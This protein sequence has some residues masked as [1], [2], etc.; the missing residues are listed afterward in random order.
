MTSFHYNY[1]NALR[2]A[3]VF[4]IFSFVKNRSC[5]TKICITK[6]VVSKIHEVRK[7]MWASP[8]HVVQ[9]VSAHELVVSTMYP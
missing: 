9:W 6:I 7:G 5:V 8:A 3:I 1:Q 2:Q 4:S